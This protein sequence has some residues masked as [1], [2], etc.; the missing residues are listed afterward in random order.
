LLASGFSDVA[1]TAAWLTAKGFPIAKS[2][3]S[4]YSRTARA[5]IKLEAAQRHPS[6]LAR[7]ELLVQARLACLAVAAQTGD[8]RG[9]Q[10][11]AEAYLT[12]AFDFRL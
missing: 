4:A 2:A 3:L 5:L 10:A 11:R 1:G 12:W 6:Q 8:H 7:L 9:I